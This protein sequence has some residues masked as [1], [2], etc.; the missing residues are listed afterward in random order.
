MIKCE[1]KPGQL[2]QLNPHTTKNPMFGGCFM[3]VTEPKEWGAQGYVQGIGENE[4]IGSQYYYRA[5]WEEMEPAGIAQWT[6][7]DDIN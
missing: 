5:R 7:G 3:V 6:V 2:V 4:K 1:L